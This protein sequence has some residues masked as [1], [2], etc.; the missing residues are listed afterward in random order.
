MVV[1]GSSLKS[2]FLLGTLKPRGEFSHTEALCELVAEKFRQYDVKSE[3]IRLVDYDIPP[4]ILN[5]L[6]PGDEWPKIL[7]KV[8]AADIIIFATPIWW[9]IHSSLIQ[10]VIERM[11]EL[12]EKLLKTGKSELANKVGGIVISGAED[13]AEHIIGNL[14]NFMVWNGLT[15]PP[16][17]S[18]SYLGDYPDNRE[19]LMKKWRG[20]PTE[21]MA[22]T[23]TRNLVFFA[24]LLRANPIPQAGEV[25]KESLAAGTI[26]LRHKK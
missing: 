3:I 14:C 1:P 20:S 15:M 23:M 13:G 4:G 18:V 10:K 26:G 8:L 2:I 24:R 11:D 6:G 21:Y 5:D 16:A 17:C 9:G 22:N 19:E 12:N 25:I 7:S